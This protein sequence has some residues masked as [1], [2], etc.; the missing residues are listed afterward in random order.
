M[1]LIIYLRKL[2]NKMLQ[3]LRYIK[4]L[5]CCKADGFVKVL[6]KVYINN[7]N[8]R[9]GRN[10]VLYPNVHIFGQGNVT[11]E[12]NVSIGDGT[13]ICAASDIRIGKDTMIAAQCYITDCNHGMKLNKLMRE[14]P[15][16]IRNTRIEDN[17][18]IGCGCKILS[19][20]EISSGV[21]VGAGTTIT[22][23]IEKNLI[24]YT[25]REYIKIERL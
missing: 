17:V 22:G 16:I 25:K 6:G 2:L 12:D 5:F 21:V 23:K 1:V 19:G 7:P 13:I 15:V 11:I 3:F 8:I 24:C 14:Q 4:I 20:S 10:V 18:W 9:F